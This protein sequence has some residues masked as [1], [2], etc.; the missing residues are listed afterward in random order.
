MTDSLRAILE[1]Q[2]ARFG[3][4]PFIKLPDGS[5]TYA[6]TNALADR[7]A[8]LLA[9]L[10]YGPGDT[11]MVLSRNRTAVLAAWFGCAK[12]GAVFMPVNALL[13]GEA[14]RMVAAHSGGR[15]AVCDPAL[16]PVL[17]AV[18]PQLPRLRHVLV[19]GGAAGVPAWGLPFDRL[20][21]EAPSSPAPGLDTE[22]PGEPA[23][24][25]YTSG[26]TGTPKGV[27]WSRNCEAV[28]A[29]NYGDE[30][31]ETAAGET[32]YTCLPMFHVT[33][34]GTILASLWRGGRVVVDDGFEPLRFWRRVRAEE[35]VLFTFVGTILS[36]LARRAPQAGDLDN[37]VRRILGGA[38]PTDLWREAERRF[39]VEILETWG[40]TETASCWMFPRRLPSEPGRVGTP[41]ARWEARIVDPSGGDVAAGATG[42]LWMRP[43]EPH[44]MFE[45]YLRPD[46]GIEPPWD[47]SG[48]YHTGDLM[49]RHPEGDYGFSGRLREAVRRR[50]EMI[51]AG[52]IEAAALQH[53]GVEEAAA[54]GVPDDQGVEEEV[55]LCVTSRPGA[56]VDAAA[57]HADL[58]GRLPQF[59][60]PRYIALLDALPKTP[61]TRVRKVELSAHGISGA[62]DA[63][64]PERGSPC[65]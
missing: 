58:A 1:R 17:D 54:V 42:E 30:L 62:W 7:T 24:L 60:V 32:T 44:V 37:P 63:R 4:R 20:L 8:H 34:Q 2:S 16:L 31:F 56:S 48:W 3:P 5:L 43:R 41:S 39:G 15:I 35:A 51:P 55:K 36:V 13:T 65:P 64:R 46:G 38:A 57:L 27:V 23:K 52:V 33:C 12:L 28:W 47:S 9:G 53:P 19:P 45:G 6:D 29:R 50:G 59:M 11:V 10:G 22:D 61:T 21:D 49:V 26:T 25:M 14:L 40:Q 18:R